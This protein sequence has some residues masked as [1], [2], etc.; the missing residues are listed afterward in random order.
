M[1]KSNSTGAK[2]PLASR[3]LAT[4]AL[5]LALI[6]GLAMVPTASASTTY[7]D[8]GAAAQYS[9]FVLG[10]TG[11]L[12]AVT[13]NGDAAVAAG[14]SLTNQ[15]PS[16]VTGNVYVDPSGSYS[17]P[18]TVG[19]HVISQS[20][21]AAR[22]DALN[23]SSAATALNSSCSGTSGCTYFSYSSISSST[24][25]TGNSGVNVVN[26]SGDVNLSNGSLTLTGPSDAYF[27][28]NVGGSITLGGSGGI[29]VAGSVPADQLIV[30]MTNSGSVN[31]HVG[32]DIQGYLLGPTS[33]GSLDGTFDAVDLGGSFSL[34]SNANVT[35]L[36]PPSCTPG[37][38][39][40]GCTPSCSSGS[41]SS[42][43]TTST[44][45]STTTSCTSGSSSSNC[46]T[47]G[48]SSSNCCTSGSS[49]CCTSGSSSTSCTTTTSS[50]TT[51]SI[52]TNTTQTTSSVLGV[53][54]HRTLKCKHGKVKKTKK[55]HGKKVSVCVKKQAKKISRKPKKISG[56]TG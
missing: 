53:T 8:L 32:N 37:S 44:T 41:G 33:G 27:V 20:E 30:N 43:C 34:M 28:V 49:S 47:S 24:T 22:S 19:G 56:F 17:G 16:K 46:C 9:V 6:A 4:G 50:S 5:V 45:S 55:V 36:T 23:A 10:N 26:V 2:T 52:T 31:T 39:G 12:S 25:V 15:A 3:A 42:T 35:G 54:K 11:N 48:S 18:G 38:G 7:P 51:T 13:V 29:V 14:A 1:D 21:S 40:S